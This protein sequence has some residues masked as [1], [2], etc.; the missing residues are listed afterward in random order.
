MVIS[1]V[2]CFNKLKRKINEK[3]TSIIRYS[4]SLYQEEKLKIQ[5]ADKKYIV[6]QKEAIEKLILNGAIF[7]SV[8]SKFHKNL[9]K[10][11]IFSFIQY[12][13]RI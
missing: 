13:L 9:N 1:E 11:H 8:L 2:L 12:N 4:P 7:S 10:K 5:R 6:I 3:G